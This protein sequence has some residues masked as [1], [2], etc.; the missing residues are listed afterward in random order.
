MI[1]LEQIVEFID[2]LMAD[3]D[4]L[5]RVSEDDLGYLRDEV[6]NVIDRGFSIQADRSIIMERRL[7]RT[8]TPSGRRS[9]SKAKKPRKKSAYQVWAD[10][11]RPKI[12]KQHPRFSFAR[13]NQELG[14]RWK[15]EKK[16][17]GMK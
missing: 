16:K 6:Q 9:A 12:K 7:A 11:E 13:M 3:E 4:G 5:G 14:K 8:Q 15:R 17:R 2:Y 10:K 1:S